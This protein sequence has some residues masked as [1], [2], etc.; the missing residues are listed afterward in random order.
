MSQTKEE[1]IQI[2]RDYF[3]NHFAEDFGDLEPIFDANGQVI[4]RPSYAVLLHILPTLPVLT[5]GLLKSK[6][7][8]L[9]SNDM[10]VRKQKV[11]VVEK[12][13]TAEEI[14]KAKKEKFQREHA[15]GFHAG[16]KNNRT[17]LDRDDQYQPRTLTEP[18]KA[19]I[20]ARNARIDEV[21]RDTM[22]TIKNYTGHSHARTYS[23]RDELTALFNQH[24]N[25]VSDVESAEKLQRTINEKINSYDR[26]TSGGVR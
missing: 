1:Q 8:E 5:A 17:E 7:A 21:I 11:V 16:M 3:I 10:L 19:A 6:V 23:R 24:K 4:C 13:P 15:D 14:A 26:G 25:K 2:L 20:N 18:E 12:Q 9:A 22:S